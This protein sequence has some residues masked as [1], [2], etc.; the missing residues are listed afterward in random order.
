VSEE[1]KASEV[2]NSTNRQPLTLADLEK[3]LSVKR[4]ALSLDEKAALLGQINTLLREPPKSRDAA[5]ALLAIRDSATFMLFGGEWADFFRRVLG[6][7]PAEGLRIKKLY[8]ENRWGEVE[9]RSFDEEVGEIGSNAQSGATATASP[10]S[11]TTNTNSGQEPMEASSSGLVE[12]ADGAP[13]PKEVKAA[14][15]PP[16][17]EVAS[18]ADAPVEVRLADLDKKNAI[19][20]RAKLNRRQVKQYKERMQANDKFPPIEVFRIDGP[21]FITDGL[22]RVEAASE[23]GLDTILCIVRDG[24]RADAV[25]AALRANFSHG[26]PRTNA[27]K[28][29]AVKLA[30]ESFAGISD[31]QIAQLC[32]VSQPFVGRVRKQLITVIGSESRL[33]RD[34]KSRRLPAR[35][36]TKPSSEAS[37]SGQASPNRVDTDGEALPTESVPEPPASS[38]ERDNAVCPGSDPNAPV[39]RQDVVQA[40][41]AKIESLILKEIEALVEAEIIAVFEAVKGVVSL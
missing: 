2:A 11:Q 6:W 16:P 28:R 33:G 15:A 9:V 10:H 37:S 1:A 7:P 24:T 39:V 36:Q 32:L 21:L 26:L 3:L 22:H 14:G 30:L 23:L 41:V 25:K 29:N 34:G 27:D 19:Q 8:E 31:H 13:A 40:V 12:T 18:T 20:C 38:T 17:A 35:A 4:R 5:E